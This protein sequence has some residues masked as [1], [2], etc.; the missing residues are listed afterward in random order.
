MCAMMDLLSSGSIPRYPRLRQA[1]RRIDTS[2]THA[3]MFQRSHKVTNMRDRINMSKL[4]SFLQ[5]F[6]ASLVMITLI[7]ATA[8]SECQSAKRD[9]EVIA[10]IPMYYYIVSP[11]D[12]MKFG[13]VFPANLQAVESSRQK[14]GVDGDKTGSQIIR[15]DSA[16]FIEIESIMEYG[17]AVSTVQVQAKYSLQ[18][19]M[20]EIRA[21]TDI[22]IV[23]IVIF[24][25]EEGRPTGR[26]R[27]SNFGAGENS[28]FFLIAPSD[29]GE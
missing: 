25:D 22:Y 24:V 12:I 28:A 19:R 27:R 13:D 4:W 11:S 9:L 16:G 10:D 20:L 5:Q 15:K 17:F 7:F 23:V 6:I 18:Q 21:E 14:A 8:C 3:Y 26:V 1:W 2:F 29:V